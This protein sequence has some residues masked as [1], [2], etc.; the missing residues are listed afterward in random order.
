VKRGA[1]TLTS[2]VLCASDPVGAWGAARLLRERY[3]LS[4]AAVSGPVTDSQAGTRYAAEDL[5]VT[6]WNALRDGPG[7]LDLVL[8]GAAVAQ[9]AG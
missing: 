9:V 6:P 4:P 8:P 1:G 5:G 3:G 2:V 7:I